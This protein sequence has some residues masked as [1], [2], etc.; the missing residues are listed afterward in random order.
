MTKEA[1]WPLTVSDVQ[2][3]SDAVAKLIIQGG[4]YGIRYRGSGRCGFSTCDC[5]SI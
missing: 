1:A 4:W 3:G 5:L 2:A